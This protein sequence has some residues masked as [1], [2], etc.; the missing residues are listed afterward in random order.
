MLIAPYPVPHQL[1][2]AT[3]LNNNVIMSMDA[4]KQQVWK[5]HVLF[6]NLYITKH[7]DE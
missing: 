1:K 5:I 2:D 4:T 7:L 6:F 3:L